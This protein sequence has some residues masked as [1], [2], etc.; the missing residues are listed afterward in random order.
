MTFGGDRSFAS[1][2]NWGVASALASVATSHGSWLSSAIRI[3]RALWGIFLLGV[4]KCSKSSA[5][6]VADHTDEVPLAVHMASAAPRSVRHAYA[7]AGPYDAGPR[8]T[9]A[10]R[11]AAHT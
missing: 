4:Q 10:A 8:D 11:G 9:N 2:Y 7:E 6:K 5:C 3:I 1:K